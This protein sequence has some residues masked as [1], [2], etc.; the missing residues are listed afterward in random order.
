MGLE[1]VPQSQRSGLASAACSLA[2]TGGG[3]DDASETRGGR[4]NNSADEGS[5]AR[6]IRGAWM[7]ACGQFHPIRGPEQSIPIQ[8]GPNRPN[9]WHKTGR[10][11]KI[12]LQPIALWIGCPRSEPLRIGG[13]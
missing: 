5:M 12:R 4:R 13:P 11:A 9:Q 6:S 10:A 1:K 3:D 2:G 8:Q 7:Q